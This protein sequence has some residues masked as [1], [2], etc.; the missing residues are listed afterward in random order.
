MA[1]GSL[2]GKSAFTRYHKLFGFTKPTGFDLPGEASGIFFSEDN[3]N[4][5][6]LATSSFGQGFNITPLQLV[7]ALTAITNDGVMVKPRIVKELV[8]DNGVVVESFETEQIR[9]VISKDT[10]KTVREILEGVVTNGTSKNAYIKGYRVA[11][12]TGTS[13]KQPR[14]NGKY[15]ASFLGFAPADDPEII[16]LVMLDEPGTHLYMGGQ[17]AAPTFKNIFDDT[18]RYLGIEPKYTEEE[19]ADKGQ[20]VPKVEGMSVEDAKMQFG[21]LKL[22]Y[23]IIGSGENVLEQ[24]PKGGITVP[25]GSVVMLYTEE[26]EVSEVV[27]PDVVGKTAVEANQILTNSRLNMKV[28]DSTSESGESYVA[29]QSPAAGETVSTGTI[30]TVEILHKDV[31]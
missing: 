24:N 21:G 8:D 29:S 3:F 1:V 27:V 11:G 6:E 18:L 15:V 30:V 16:G 4:E 2:V 13:E 19:M 28:G 9:Q 26:S 17:I 7:T 20:M 10:A 25:S 23:K 22:E 14:G 12:K 31:H 5:L